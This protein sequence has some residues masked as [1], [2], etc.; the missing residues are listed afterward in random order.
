MSPATTVRTHLHPVKVSAPP[1]ARPPAITLSEALR[2]A[3]DDAGHP[4]YVQGTLAV[5]LA[6]ASDEQLFGPQTTSSHDLPC[7]QEWAGRIGQAIV[8]VMSGL[9]P[10]AQVVRWTT[11]D[12]YAAV[13]RRG[14]LA[15][16]RRAAGARS[17]ARTARI[18]TVRVCEPADGVAECSLVIGEGTRV[19]AMALR[20]TGQDGRWRVEALQLG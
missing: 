19:R 14:A 9:R 7:A 11:P 6:A 10:P 5:D 3:E 1:A 18:H 8:E 17:Q 13:A 12:V 2:R 20:L 16:R 4:A 15:G